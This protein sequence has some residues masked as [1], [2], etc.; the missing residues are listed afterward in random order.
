MC[1]IIPDVGFDGNN[2]NTP[3]L[4]KHVHHAENIAL[5]RPEFTNCNYNAASRCWAVKH[6]VRNDELTYT[7]IPIISRVFGPYF[8]LQTVY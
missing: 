4:F 2:V 7:F 5:V 1:K 6:R 8:K 3:G